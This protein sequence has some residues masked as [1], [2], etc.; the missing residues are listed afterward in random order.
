PRTISIVERCAV[1]RLQA[2]VYI[3]LQEPDRALSEGLECLRHAGLDLSQR[4]TEAQARVSYDRICSRLDGMGLDDLAARPMM[5]DAASCAFLDVLAALHWC[6][7]VTHRPSEVSIVCAAIDLVLDRGIHDAASWAFAHLGYQAAWF[8]DDFDRAFRFGQLGYDLIERTGL[9]RFEG[10]VCLHVSTLIMPWARHATQC[11]PVIQRTF[12]VA[13]YTGDRF[14]AAAGG[15]VLLSNLL[16]AGDSLVDAA[17]E[18]EVCLA[19]CRTGSYGDYFDTLRT[20]S[21]LVRSLR[22]LTPRFGS[23]DDQQ[24]DERDIESGFATRPHVEAIEYW[25]WIRKLQA[26]FLAGDY[27]AALEASQ[28]A[29]RLVTESPGMLQP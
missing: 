26:R 18:A 25:Y 2:N 27:A 11:R 8:F 17:R 23:F 10:V 14:L 28:Q 24:F 13:D 6:A 9:R 19:L 7:A 4:P 22:G 5:T 3:A 12:E 16:L 20:Q 21:A 1:V 29:R 15:N